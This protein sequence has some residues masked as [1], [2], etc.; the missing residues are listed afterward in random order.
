V[1]K[2][3]I[4][5]FGIILI[6]LNLLLSP[7][8]CILAA[9]EGLLLWFNKVLPSLLP[10]IILINVLSGLNIMQAIG[11]A[12][13]PITKRLW[14]LPGSSLF[15]FIMGFIAGYPM[16]AKII[17]QLVDSNTLT[18]PEAQKTLCFSNNCGPLF[19]VGTVGTL[20]LG[21]SSIG[22]FL[23]VVHILS[24]LI[25]SIIFS[26]FNNNNAAKTQTK[27]HSTSSVSLKFSSLFNES[28]KNAMD[29]IVYI[30][31]FIIF[32][33]VIA[34][35]VNVSPIMVHLIHSLR[36]LIISPEIFSGMITGL[37]ELSNGV[38][39]LSGSSILSV[40]NLALI[41]FMIGFGGL[42]I[43]F[44]TSY[45]LSNCG[46]SLIPYSTAKLMQGI[47]SFILVYLLYPMAPMYTLKTSLSYELKWFVLLMIFCILFTYVV[48][49]LNYL[50]DRK[51]SQT[52]KT[53]YTYK[54]MGI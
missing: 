42:C 52:L 34:R 15:V 41:S 49:F 9:K 39:S 44:Q 4:T 16:G 17:S 27:K 32:F 36:T 5:V 25:I 20:M 11:T 23:L 38:N 47:I 31:G 18:I 14:N 46:F 24:A 12:A 29:T 50:Y 53:N 22:Y 33:S 1:S 43:F 48:K 26:P 54:R 2:K 8:I 13:S 28:V 6:I 19:I 51:V 30:G 3:Y 35:I 10:F 37:L 45:V 21:N 7:D 40:L